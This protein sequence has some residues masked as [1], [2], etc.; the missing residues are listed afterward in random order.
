VD[1]RSIRL[2]QLRTLHE[3]EVTSFRIES[4]EPILA[5][6]DGEALVFDSPL[7][8]SIRPKGL[9]VVVP[10]GTRP[11]YQPLGEVVAARLLD[12]AELGGQTEP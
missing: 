1:V 12:L 11:G 9:R 6:L 10:A 7:N 8:I 3:W 4:D 5:G 2:D